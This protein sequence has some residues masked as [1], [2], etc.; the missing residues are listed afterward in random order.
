MLLLYDM[1]LRFSKYNFSLQL[2]IH[3]NPQEAPEPC[4]VSICQHSVNICE[5]WLQ[6]Y[7][8]PSGQVS[9]PKPC[10]LSS[11]R[12]RHRSKAL[13]KQTNQNNQTIKKTINSINNIPSP[14]KSVNKLRSSSIHIDPFCTFPTPI[15]VDQRRSDMIRDD[16]RMS[17]HSP[18]NFDP[19]A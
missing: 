13:Q 1:F 7:L 8:A 17:C 5:L 15:T 18:L 12:H 3:R 2:E 9:S 10:C 11:S 6:T 14:C 4:T 19:L 16:R